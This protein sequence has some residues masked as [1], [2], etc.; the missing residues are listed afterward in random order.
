MQVKERTAQNFNLI[1]QRGEK[2][3]ESLE[4]AGSS[5]YIGMMHVLYIL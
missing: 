4:K 1:K 2:L 5:L 3:E